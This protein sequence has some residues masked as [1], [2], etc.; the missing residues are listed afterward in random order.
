[1]PVYDPI[2]TGSLSGTNGNDV[3]TGFA[4]NFSTNQIHLYGR[5]G[6]D[7]L[8]LDFQS[9]T[10]YAFGH[11]V[12]GDGSADGEG[13]NDLATN[14]SMDHFKFKNVH[15]VDERAVGRLE[16]FDLSRDKI[17][18]RGDE[19]AKEH[20]ERGYGTD[21]GYNWRIVEYDADTRDSVDEAQ[22]WLLIDTNGGYIFY[23]LEGARVTDSNSTSAYRKGA[24][25]GGNQEAH[26]LGADGGHRVTASELLA[27][28]TVK[29]VDGINYVPS[30]F[31][32][33]GG[34][35]R[36]DDDDVFAD[37]NGAIFEGSDAGDLLAAGLNDDDVEGKAGNDRIWGGSGDDTIDGGSGNDTLDGGVSE[38]F[39]SEKGF[40]YG[41]EDS[42]VAQVFR[43][44]LGALERLPDEGGWFSWVD[45]MENG[46]SLTSVANGFANSD[47]FQNRYGA[48]SNQDYVTRLYQNILD[49]QP[50]QG[51]L[52]AWMGHLSNGM[53]R[54][55]VL[56]RFTESSEFKTNTNDLYLKVVNTNKD[57]NDRLTGGS[58]TDTFEFG[59]RFGYDHVTDFNVS[60]N[61]KI[62]FSEHDHFTTFSSSS[63]HIFKEE[64]VLQHTAGTLIF[65]GEGNSVMLF[66][67]NAN[68]LSANDFIF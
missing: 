20:I 4:S 63:F 59:N 61:E 18:I 33:Q 19:L 29:Y 9:I 2:Y 6:V 57:L 40:H 43:L 58:G 31:S 12:R 26:F 8:N 27:L 42:V 39:F 1:M 62:D 55:E 25:N 56:W 47:E 45:A 68:S 51:G 52:N 7:T 23:A 48:T 37:A 10:N 67:V 50:D 17:Y 46:A 49:R 15:L 13:G 35:V 21:A 65:D 64:H 41:D 36:N 44:Y 53:S 22:Q 32:A 38:S 14:R 16:D 60:G 34:I 28:E 66:G 54:G 30:G 11:H 3:L 24:A 5:L